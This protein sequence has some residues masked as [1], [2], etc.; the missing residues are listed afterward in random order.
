MYP[1]GRSPPAPLQAMPIIE[2]PFQRVGIDLIGPITPVSGRGNRF[3]L[4]LVDFATK[5]PEVVPLKNIDTISVAEALIG[6]FARTGVPDEILSDQGSQFKSDMMKEIM[7]LLSVSQLH[8]TPYHAQCNGLVERMNGTLKCMLKKLMADKPKDWDRY[9][10]PA[11]FA[12]RE[13]PQASTGFSPFELL[14]GRTPKGPTQILSEI[15]SGKKTDVEVRTTY[16][17]VAD[18]KDTMEYTAQ[19]A[20][21]AMEK[22]RIT[23][24]RHYDRKTVK[25]ELSPGDDVLVLLP[26]DNNKLLLQWQGPFKVKAKTAP[27]DYLI[28]GSH[29]KDRVF[30]INMLKKYFRREPDGPYPFI[31]SVGVILGE[32]AV[33]D[34]DVESVRLRDVSL[35]QKETV[36]DVKYNPDLLPDQKRD[37]EHVFQKHTKIM[38]DLPGDTDL[39]VHSIRLTE[40]KVVNIKPYPLPF[41]SEQVVKEE[42]DKLLKLDI[43]EPSESPYCAPLVLVKKPDNSVRMCLDFRGLNRITVFDSEPIPDVEQLFTSLH[44]KRYHTKIDLSKG[45][46]Q[47]RLAEQDRPKTAF[48]TP[49]GLFQ[50]KRLPFGTVTA[51]CTFARMMRKLHLEECNAISFFDDILVSTKLWDDHASS[52]DKVLT[53][54]EKNGL[55]VR[56]TKVEAGF[57]EIE[58]LGHIVGSGTMRPTQAKVSKILDIATPKTKK[59]VRALIG[60]TSYYRRYMDNFAHIIAPLADL[61]KKDKPTKVRWSEECQQSLDSIKKLLSSSPVIILPDFEKQF[62]LR[63]DASSRGLGAALMQMA[64]DGELHPVLYASR[65]LLDRETRYSTVERECLAVVWG[66]DKFSRYLIGKHFVIETDH[67]PL[68]FLGKNK[69]TNGRLMRWSLALQEYK[70]SVVPISGQSNCE[71]DVLSRLFPE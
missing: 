47:I 58:F 61:T 64:E 32:S 25:R 26:T 27:C 6:I 62:I 69:T 30:H 22:A 4:T 16:Q 49:Q 46:F 23:H 48:R 5:F 11:L 42:I 15:W 24:K 52:V 29:D 9:I 60:L 53:K 39:E 70:F 33:Q 40:D 3:A 67:R 55:T 51:P 12:Y 13:I 54:L 20:K 45:Y 59:Q 63:T 1:K 68:T 38:T 18:L 37:L 65:K 34:T 17:Y 8:S 44:D 19:L 14:Y 10:A 28:K 36:K 50:F 66:I 2:V 43:I 71:A 56:P 57:E 35:I 21:E 31:S 41:G 7:R